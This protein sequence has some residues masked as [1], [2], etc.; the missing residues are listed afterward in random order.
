MI[1]LAIVQT[2]N[3]SLLNCQNLFSLLPFK[4]TGLQD[5][6]L[7]NEHPFKNMHRYADVCKFIQMT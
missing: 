3:I 1:S 7:L 5:C 4:I 6:I 2:Y